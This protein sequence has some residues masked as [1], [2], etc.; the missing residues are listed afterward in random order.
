MTEQNRTHYSQAHNSN[1]E[2]QK[3]DAVVVGAGQAGLA[4]GYYLKQLGLEFVMLDAG[5]R[6]GNSWRN[7]WDSLRLFSPACY[8]ELPGMTYP[9]ERFYY[10]TKDEFADYLERYAE[11]FIL[12]VHLKTTVKSVSRRAD[13]YFVDVGRKQ[14]LA[15]NVISAMSSFQKPNIPAFAAELDSSIR[16]LHSS[17]YRRPQQLQAGDVLVAGA[18]NSGAE[19]AIDISGTGR[20][21]LS[22]RHPGHIPFRIDTKAAEYLFVPFVLDILFHR[23]LTVDTPMGRKM[24]DRLFNQGGPLVRSKPADLDDAGIMR[25]P[26]VA[27]V[28]DGLPLLED[29]HVLEVENVIWATGYYPN[30]DWIDLPIFGVDEHPREPQH[31]R[32]VVTNMPGFYFVGLFFQYAI[33]SNMIFGMVRDAKYIAD[34]IEARRGAA[35][36]NQTE[37]DRVGEQLL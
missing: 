29:G 22:G 8:N 15:G 1:I 13:G 19:I 21:W 37:M 35:G 33:S 4:T 18:A 32:G 28:R 16:Q 14:Y 20:T 27:G 17:Q 5:E 24:R 30:F 36:A 10:P 12:P 9:G 11:K 34:H 7:R 25:L 26:R 31:S 23:V 6:I 2:P 3:V